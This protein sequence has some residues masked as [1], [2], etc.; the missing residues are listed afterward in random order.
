MA[1]PGARGA[2]SATARHR[3]ASGVS[4]SCGERCVSKKG[5]R[6][7]RSGSS[8]VSSARSSAT[9]SSERTPPAAE[10]AEAS[11]ERSAHSCSKLHEPSSSS[12]LWAKM[13]SICIETSKAGLAAAGSVAS[14]GSGSGSAG[15]AAFGA[16][17]FGATAF[18]GDFFARSLGDLGSLGVLPS[19]LAGPLSLAVFFVAGLDCFLGPFFLGEMADADAAAGLAAV[20]SLL[21]PPGDFEA[22]GTLSA[23]FCT[24]SSC[25]LK[26]SPLVGA[27]WLGGLGAEKKPERD[28]CFSVLMFGGVARSLVT[29]G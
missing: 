21:L 9:C 4:S 20:G 19:A 28:A 25:G 24:G 6:V 27:A 10:A 1:R 16:A 8:S 3:L 13:R 17:T 11:P 12:S 5:S 15:A 29:G 23:G 26:F 14:T 7:L 2:P 22:A 18:L